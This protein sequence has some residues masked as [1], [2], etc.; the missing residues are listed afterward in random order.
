MNL[1]ITRLKKIKKMQQNKVKKLK[2][3]RHL[4][5][6]KMGPNLKIH[7]RKKKKREKAKQ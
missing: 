5:Q 1:M 6:M 4:Q 7:Q 2:K 3:N